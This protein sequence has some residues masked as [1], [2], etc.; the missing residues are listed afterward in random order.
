MITAVASFFLL[1]N[2]IM[3]FLCIIYYTFSFSCAIES[4]E[5]KV[6][7]FVTFMVEEVK[8]TCKH[9]EEKKNKTHL[10]IRKENLMLVYFLPVEIKNITIFFFLHTIKGMLLFVFSS[11]K[12]NQG[13]MEYG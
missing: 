5:I 10:S 7:T 1:P 2:E 13:A 4:K 11:L 6:Y 3:R 12:G 8:N 9:L